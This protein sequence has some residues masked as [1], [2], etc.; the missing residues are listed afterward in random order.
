[1]VHDA[2]GQIPA[3]CPARFSNRGWVDFPLDAD[4]YANWIHANSFDGII[5]DYN[6][7]PDCMKDE[8]IDKLVKSISQI[9]LS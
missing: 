6:S 2:Y 3:H 9:I 5:S 8:N 1:M 7:N 4:K